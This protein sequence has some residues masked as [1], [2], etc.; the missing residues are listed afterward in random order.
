[1][2]TSLVRCSICGYYTEHA[3]LLNGSHPACQRR[4]KEREI[5]ER[6]DS[7]TIV[8][9]LGEKDKMR[10]AEHIKLL[11]K[12]IKELTP[13]RPGDDYMDLLMLRTFLDRVAEQTSLRTASKKN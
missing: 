2:Y 6:L 7:D 10:L 5:K 4:Q 8:L 12:K 11:D 13:R 1:M 9:V 3:E